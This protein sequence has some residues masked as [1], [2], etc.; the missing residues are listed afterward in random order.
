MDDHIHNNN[1]CN[2]LNWRS[3]HKYMIKKEI[4]FYSQQILKHTK[5]Q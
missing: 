4:L 5:P 1:K 3:F 2:L